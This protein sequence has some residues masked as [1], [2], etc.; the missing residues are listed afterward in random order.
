MSLTDPNVRRLLAYLSDRQR[1]TTGRTHYV[2]LLHRMAP[3]EER[4]RRPTPPSMLDEDEHDFWKDHGV[5]I[6][7]LQTLGSAQLS[8][9]PHPLLRRRVG[10]QASRPAPGVGATSSY[11]D[12][13]PRRRRAA[14]AGH[15]GAGP[16]ARRRR[17]ARQAARPH[18]DQPVPAAGQGRIPPRVLVGGRAR[19]ARRRAPSSPVTIASPSPRSRRR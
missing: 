17:R 15:R 2:V 16:R 3:G 6:L 7:R 12:V 10:S 14:G 13:R 5:K 9:A 8:L 4:H 19:R 11:G 18:R 1:S